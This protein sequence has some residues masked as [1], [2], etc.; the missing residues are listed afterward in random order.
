[1]GGWIG[2]FLGLVAEGGQNGI[3]PGLNKNGPDRNFTP[4]SC[5]VRLFLCLRQK[6]KFSYPHRA[7]VNSPHASVKWMSGEVGVAPRPMGVLHSLPMGSP[8]IGITLDWEVPGS[9]SKLPWYALRENY[10]R[11]FVERD[12]K[13]V[14]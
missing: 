5:S 10:V 3:C 8:I 4:F 13:S 9:Y 12:R 14:V 2:K 11:V 7:R 1:M 6:W